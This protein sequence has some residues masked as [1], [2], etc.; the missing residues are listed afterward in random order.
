MKYI[1]LGSNSFSGFSF[2]KF[3]LKKNKKVLGISRSKLPKELKSYINI[4][5]NK[6]FKFYQLDLNKNLDEIIKIINKQDEKFNIINFSSQSMVA[7]SWLKPLDWYKTNVISQIKLVE[8]IKNN[9]KLRCYLNFSTPEVYGSTNSIIKEN[10]N[11]SP[12]TPYAN[13]RAT[14]DHHLLNLYKFFKFPVIFTR[15]SN[16]YGP[17]QKLYR[18]IPKTI[19]S[20]L[21]N[22][23]I[24]LNGGGKS[25]RN[26]IYIDD[27]SIAIYKI[28]NHPSFGSSYHISSNQFV[29]IEQLVKLICKIMKKNFNT[30]VKILPE[31]KGKDFAYK[32]SSNK[33][34]K[35]FNWKPSIN[36]NYG[37]KETI[38]WVNNNF[39]DL[40]KLN[41]I[42]KHKK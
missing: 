41:L 35:E 40:K 13:S 17:G 37:I 3:L 15:A 24:P 8:Q 5:K 28:L 29:S 9:K 14:F 30:S 25:I 34:R 23:K 39:E 38:I 10:F 18:I 26:F 33:L 27:V 22:K 2:I 12:S 1:I 16:V 19:I 36:L 42:Y 4:F 20:L 31:N 6:R 32:L 11:F 7:Q 21:L